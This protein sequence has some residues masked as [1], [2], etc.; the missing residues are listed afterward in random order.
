[1][2]HFNKTKNNMTLTQKFNYIKQHFTYY[3][4]NSWNR[5]T[6]IANNIK[7]YNLPLT[8]EQRDK[9]YDIICDE[10]LSAELWDCY[11]IP[12]IKNFEEKYNNNYNIYSNGRN[13]GYFVLVGKKGY[14]VVNEDIECAETYKELVSNFKGDYG[15]AHLDA[16]REARQEIEDTFDLIVEFDNACDETLAEF[17]Y[18]LDNVDIQTKTYTKEIEYKT[19]LA[20]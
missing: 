5:D 4:M 15:W 8:K 18:V 20:E 6:S 10:C 11:L 1:M 16:Q 13:N 7:I 3:T 9:A 2:K 17:I 12:C 14:K 19:L